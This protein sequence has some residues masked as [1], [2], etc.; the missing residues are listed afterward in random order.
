[1]FRFISTINR[2]ARRAATEVKSLWVPREKEP[3]A[4]IG[5]AVTT[6]VSRSITCSNSR[7]IWLKLTGTKRSNSRPV[8]ICYLTI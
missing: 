7:A 6:N 5:D 2:L 1:M 8:A 4:A 3:P